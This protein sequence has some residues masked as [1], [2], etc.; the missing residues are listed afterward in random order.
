MRRFPRSPALFIATVLLLT[1]C[2]HFAAARATASA[3]PQLTPGAPSDP[4]RVQLDPASTITVETL[5]AAD[6][7]CV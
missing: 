4:C 2:D 5:R 7:S 6:G 3:Q 1:A